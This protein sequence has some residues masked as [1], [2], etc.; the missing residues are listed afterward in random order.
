V[1]N[2]RNAKRVSCPSLENKHF[3]AN[4]LAVLIEILTQNNMVTIGIRSTVQ[5]L[6]DFARFSGLVVFDKPAVILAEDKHINTTIKKK[7]IK[8]QNIPH[9][10]NSSKI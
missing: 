5:E 3:Q 8:K 10:Q 9:S 2:L 7:V 6:I 1:C 4:E